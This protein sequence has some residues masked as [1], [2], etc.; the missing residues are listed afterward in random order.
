MKKA[1]IDMKALAT[2]GWLILVVIVFASFLTNFRVGGQAAFLPERCFIST[3]AF[4]CEE[5]SASTGIIIL[6]IRNVLKKP[7]E[8][9]QASVYKDE[10]SCSLQS[11]V[12]IGSQKSDNLILTKG[13]TCIDL[14]IPGKKLVGNVSITYK[15][16]LKSETVSGDV[17][18]I[19]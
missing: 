4:Y 10:N 6:R 13:P 7:I 9:T 14:T 12:T 1:Q 8:I 15:E 11:P 2:Y 17:V 19:P 5:Y 3:N 18:V 16:G